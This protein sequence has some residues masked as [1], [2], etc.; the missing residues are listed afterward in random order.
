MICIKCA[1]LSYGCSGPFTLEI[2]TYRAS[3]NIHVMTLA[4]IDQ[5]CVADVLF[6]VIPGKLRLDHLIA[7]SNFLTRGVDTVL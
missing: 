6:R 4:P 2:E 1:C 3:A 5:S 7:L